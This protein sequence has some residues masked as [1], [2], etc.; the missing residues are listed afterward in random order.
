MDPR[1][2]WP[3]CPPCAARWLRAW[4]RGCVA[5]CE[6]SPEISFRFAFRQQRLR[7]AK[8]VWGR[9]PL[10][11]SGLAERGQRPLHRSWVKGSTAVEAARE[12]P[13]FRTL[14]HHGSAIRCRLGED[15]EGK[16]HLVNGVLETDWAAVD[17]GHKVRVPGVD[18]H[19]SLNLPA[20]LARKRPREGQPPQ[21]RQP[22]RPRPGRGPATHQIALLGASGSREARGEHLKVT[23]DRRAPLRGHHQDRIH[24]RSRRASGRAGLHHRH[25]LLP[26]RPTRLHSSADR[27]QLNDSGRLYV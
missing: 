21:A 4:T 8:A 15:N 9:P 13:D 10:Q 27:R 14:R 5:E 11:Q 22:Q 18:N 19:D 3:A 17:R 6:L 12:R 7:K 23:R 2:L 1:G 16:A 25:A 20:R 24:P 26:P